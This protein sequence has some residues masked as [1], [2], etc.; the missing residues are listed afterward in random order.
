M[1]DGPYQHCRPLTEEEYAALKADIDQNGV[2]EYVHVDEEGQILVGHHRARA[3][4]E[5]GIEYPRHVVIGLS[6][7]DKHE[8]AVRLESLGRAKDIETKKYTA[9]HLMDDPRVKITQR[10]LAELLGIPR[11]TVHDWAKARDK[12]RAAAQSSNP[13]PDL[14][15]AEPITVENTRGQRR[16][17][18]YTSHRAPGN[19]TVAARNDAEEDDEGAPPPGTS[20]ERPVDPTRSKPRTMGEI[21]G[22]NPEPFDDSGL[23]E[24]AE[25][26]RRYQYVGRVLDDV[27]RCVHTYGPEIMV[28][29]EPLEDLPALQ[30]NLAVVIDWLTRARQLALN[31]RQQIRSVP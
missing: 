27:L 9:L 16:P 23:K 3:A 28:E 19:G 17:T 18:S 11:S 26:K 7:Q 5:L 30:K 31:P 29:S 24:L 20:Q 25:R 12:E 22:P 2:L 4:T 21:L 13:D 14:R 10:S 15:I 6:E 1:S 8:Y